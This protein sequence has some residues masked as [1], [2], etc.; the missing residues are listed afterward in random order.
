MAHHV[1]ADV[2]GVEV[3]REH[4]RHGHPV[5]LDQI[6]QLVDRIGRVDEHALALGA[7]AD[8]I[9]EVHHLLGDRVADASGQGRHGRIVNHATWMIGVATQLATHRD[10]WR[11]KVIL[12]IQ[13]AEEV[14]ERAVGE[15]VGRRGGHELPA[16]LIQPAL[17]GEQVE[18]GRPLGADQVVGVDGAGRESDPSADSLGLKARSIGG[19]GYDLFARGVICSRGNSTSES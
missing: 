3:R 17:A 13:P 5:G 19:R 12:A 6:E 7:V 4:A 16:E 11:G 9:D 10:L 8:G 15:H 1:A 14:E 18:Q 2:V